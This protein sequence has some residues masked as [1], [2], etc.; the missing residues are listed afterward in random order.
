[1]A[2]EPAYEIVVEAT[3]DQPEEEE[4]SIDVNVLYSRFQDKL[5]KDLIRTNRKNDARQNQAGRS[6]D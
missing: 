4:G 5:Q 6:D 3:T 1:M 2:I